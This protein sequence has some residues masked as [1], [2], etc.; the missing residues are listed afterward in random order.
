MKRSMRWLVSSVV[1]L[2][3]GGNASAADLDYLR[4]SEVFAPGPAGYANWSGFFIGGEFSYGFAHAEFGGRADIVLS[5]LLSTLPLPGGAGL[6]S[7]PG[8]L[9]P[10]NKNFT[11]FGAFAGYDS[12][13]ENA[14]LGVEVNYHYAGLNTSA[15]QA[16]AFGIPAAGFPPTAFNVDMSKTALISLTDYAT[17]RGRAGWAFGSFLPYATVGLAVGR[18]DITNSARVHYT[19]ISGGAVVAD[20]TQVANEV[21]SDQ[22]SVGYALGAGIDYRLWSGMFLRG[23]YEYVDFLKFSDRKF[24]M[25]NLR[26]GLG[27]KF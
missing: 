6:A 10:D 16:A 17:F 12:Q 1:A 14:V 25:H 21:Q 26:A 19:A 11:S 5:S 20:V 7:V 22:F 15:T 24:S 9:L 13:W 4:G 8:P 23:E 18:A 3:F 2:G 27:Y